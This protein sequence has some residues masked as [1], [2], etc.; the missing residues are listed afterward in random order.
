MEGS[1]FP[2]HQLWILERRP[3]S[4]KIRGNYFSLLGL[5]YSI[6]F[7]YC[8]HGS[9]CASFLL[10]FWC[11]FLLPYD[12]CPLISNSIDV[13]M[14]SGSYLGAVRLIISHCP[15]LTLLF[16]ATVS[17]YSI[18]VLQFCCWL[19]GSINFHLVRGDLVLFSYSPFLKRIMNSGSIFS[20]N[21]RRRRD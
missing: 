3:I 2:I 18:L 13:S 14:V 9:W 5:I 11:Y 1:T 8:L 19:L 21:M 16:C 4:F 17:W 6:I 10:V 7:I 20:L 15:L 12:L